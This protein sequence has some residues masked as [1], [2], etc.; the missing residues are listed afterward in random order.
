MNSLEHFITVLFAP[1]GLTSIKL[2][3]PV[4]SYVVFAGELSRSFVEQIVR[5]LHT[6]LEW[7]IWVNHGADH[8]TYATPDKWVEHERQNNV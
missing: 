6:V 8:E 4:G 3:S 5:E 1:N 2:T 7:P